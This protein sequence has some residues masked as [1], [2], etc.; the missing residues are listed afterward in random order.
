MDG[1]QLLLVLDGF[2]ALAFL[3]AAAWAM[4]QALIC[5]VPWLRARSSFTSPRALSLQELWRR[6]WGA[7]VVASL[8]FVTSAGWSVILVYQAVGD[9][10]SETAKRGLH[11]LSG[12]LGCAALCGM[13]FL[14]PGRLPRQSPRD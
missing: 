2:L 8:C 14:L 11:F 13:L 12:G 6:A 5:Y 9:P 1:K 10:W 3:A 4:L 7:I